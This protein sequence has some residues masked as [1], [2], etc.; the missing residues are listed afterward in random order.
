MA[1]Y[2]LTALW[3]VSEAFLGGIL[4]GLH[5][6]VTGIFLGSFAVICL[7]ALYRSTS[8]PNDLL[9][10]TL[11]VILVKASLSP[12]SPV[13]AYF[14]VGFQ[15]IAA[16]LIFSSPI[17]HW[18]QCILLGL[19]ALVESA[20]QRILILLLLFGNNLVDAFDG[21]IHSFVK[22]FG[23]EA[24]SYT[25][26]LAGIYV[27]IHILVGIW[28]GLLAYR[29]PEM[30]KKNDETSLIQTEF[31]SFQLENTTPEK[32]KSKGSFLWVIWA[33]LTLLLVW[34]LYFKNQIALPESKILLLLLRSVTIVLVWIFV[35]NPI[36][37]LVF[38]K[39]VG[40]QKNRFQS[41][42]HDVL[43]LMPEIKRILKF[44]VMKAKTASGFS[45]FPRF[46]GIVFSLI[47]A[48]NEVK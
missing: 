11:L 9:K 6:P 25:Y 3:A 8:K 4:H 10:A 48:Q 29:L 24:F 21:F 27:V 5:L 33:F 41:E 44:G 45:K 12:Q 13:A 34:N 43:H 37:R 7:A 15:G 19:I 32:K 30:V 35:A 46:V 42:L 20:I 28:A 18:L 26:L 1:F 22:N 39:W 31:V 38:E 47:L 23:L 36:L 17:S 40:K 2:R 14:A 16:F